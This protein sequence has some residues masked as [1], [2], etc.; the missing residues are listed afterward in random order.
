MQAS[1]LAVTAQAAEVSELKPKLGLA[2]EDLVHINKRFD[3]VQGMF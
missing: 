3:E 1:L 2:D